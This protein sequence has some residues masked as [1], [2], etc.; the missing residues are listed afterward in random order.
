MQNEGVQTLIYQEFGISESAFKTLEEYKLIVKKMK[1]IET[2]IE[3]I[4]KNEADETCVEFYE[5]ELKHLETYRQIKG[6][7]DEELIEFEKEFGVL[8]NSFKELYRYKNG[9][10][11]PFNIL[12]PCY[13]DEICT[14]QFL[15]SLDE[16]RKVKTYFC[17]KDMHL[18]D[19]VDESEL[20]NLD[21]RIR[22]YL[23]HTN[24]LP[25]A[26]MPNG[27]IHLM[28]DFNPTEV[29]TVG[30]II[31]FI[32]DPDFVYYVSDSLENLLEDAIAFLE[33]D[34]AYEEYQGWS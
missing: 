25:F 3:E 12:F 22:P 34:G 23:Q 19:Y 17:N 7:T 20:E 5:D 31:I 2:L 6:A 29:G 24:W 4:L 18:K 15:L 8:P 11:Y 32:H 9:S 27:A 1:K 14:P 33:D 30:Q 16:I 10:G 21:K 26:E 28:L 13:D